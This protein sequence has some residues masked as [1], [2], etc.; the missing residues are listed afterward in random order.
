MS[1]T[2]PSAAELLDSVEPYLSSHG[3]T[4][5]T[6]SGIPGSG[7]STLLSSLYT[8]ILQRKLESEIKAISMDG[9]HYSR[10]GLEKMSDP[11]EAIRRRG[12]PFTFD[13][14]G[15]ID[16]IRRIKLGE[17]VGCPTFD[18]SVK[19]PVFDTVTIAKE[20]IIFIEGLYL[21]YTEAPWNRIAEY[22][23]KAWF[24]KCDVNVASMRVVRRHV[25]SGIT[26]DIEAAWKRWHES[27]KINADLILEHIGQIDLNIQNL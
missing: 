21:S 9:W 16:M 15:C 26:D 11:K 3:R 14:E 23:D 17:Q 13:S 24:L 10:S 18:H 8:E 6:I 5:I 7:K 19:D 2:K 22:V 4:V 25:H 20:K 1:F 27:D 12:A